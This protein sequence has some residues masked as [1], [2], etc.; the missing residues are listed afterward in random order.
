MSPA[1]QLHRSAMLVASAA[2]TAY[3]QGDIET[4]HRLTLDAFAKEKEAAQFLQDKLEAEPTRAILYRG[5][6]QLAF[7]CGEYQ[8]AER[9]IA[10]ALLGNPPDELRRE[11][12]DLNRQIQETLEVLQSIESVSTPDYLQQLREQALHVWVQPKKPTHLTAVYLDNVIEV[13]KRVKESFLNFVEI[14]FWKNF[15]N[16]GFKEPDKL[17]AGLRSEANPLLVN[18]KFS[19]FAASIS[20]DLVVMARQY[21]PE[22]NTWKR[23][24][25]ARYRTEV[26]EASNYES[27]EAA[28]QIAEPY[29]PQERRRI[30]QPVVE[31][32]KESN[33]YSLA[34]TDSQFRQKRRVYKPVAKRV[35]NI[36]IPALTE[37]ETQR[38]KSLFQIMGMG[39]A[40]SASGKLDIISRQEMESASFTHTLSHIR[41]EKDELY[42]SEEIDITIRY[43]K[44]QF[45]L[46]FSPLQLVLAANDYAGLVKL[47]QQQFIAIYNY[48]QERPDDILSADEIIQKEYFRR[49]VFSKG[50][51]S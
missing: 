47:F 17:L 11:L 16:A 5:A 15:H 7:N 44:P 4:Y 39:D 49:V 1:Q 13:L 41:S 18:L 24:V 40:E 10:Q 25:F 3:L 38:H 48:L 35:R 42:L 43:E 27:E 20:S 8:E 34:L 6:A 30:F 50:A 14:D 23:E 28:K 31:L 37:E 12:R 22:I 29:T 9:L 19:S 2:Q 33:N 36:L 26:F 32:F 45:Y 46:D 21:T 51:V